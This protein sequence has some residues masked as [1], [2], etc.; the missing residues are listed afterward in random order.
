MFKINTP[1]RLSV[2][3]SIC[4]FFISILFSL[5]SFGIFFF[6]LLISIF[7]FVI[8]FYLVKKFFYE[9]IRVIY[10]IIYKFKGTASIR[11]LDID[12]VEKEAEEWAEAKEEEL[13]QMK[14]DESY[15]REFIGNVSHELKTPIFNIQGYVQ[16]LLDGGL[17]DD[18]INMKYLQ[19][20]DKSVERMINIVE[21][22][23]V[24]S[25][26]ETEQSE[27]DI[28]SFNINIPI[29]RVDFDGLGSNYKYFR[30]ISYPLLGTL[31]VRALANDFETGI[32][33]RIIC[34]DQEYSVEI[35]VDRSVCSS[36]FACDGEGQDDKA[37]KFVINGLLLESY[38]LSNS[39]SRGD[40]AIVD[41]NYSFSIT[42]SK[43]K[44]IFASGSF[45]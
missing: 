28:Q 13:R 26:L 25:R 34:N 3:L 38:S 41:L 37:M 11:E 4:V 44:G 12:I 29:Q 7:S 32:L 24:I 22:L 15:R 2:L 9:K 27:L 31:N 16:T 1:I 43:R 5:F 45:D 17:Q 42:K 19:R 35:S 30:K 40:N 10:K 21:D 8:I 14:K 18:T 23:E 36:I 20:A 39:V 33:D 6:P